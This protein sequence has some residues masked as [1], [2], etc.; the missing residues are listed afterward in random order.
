MVEA[1]SKNS[2]FGS[3]ILEPADQLARIRDLFEMSYE[4]PSRLLLPSLP[5]QLCITWFSAP[6]ALRV[7]PSMQRLFLWQ[8]A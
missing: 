5:P 2:G 6:P 3:Q 8:G 1:R 7:R 4:V